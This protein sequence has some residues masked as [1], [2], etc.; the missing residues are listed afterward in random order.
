MC[1]SPDSRFLAVASKSGCIYIFDCNNDYKRISF[2]GHSKMVRGV[3]FTPD[4]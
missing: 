3:C 2:K 1:V 4:S